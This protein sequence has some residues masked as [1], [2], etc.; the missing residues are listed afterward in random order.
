MVYLVISLILFLIGYPITYRIEKIKLGKFKIPDALAAL[1]TIIL[2]LSF[3]V[4][5]FFLILPPLINEAKTLSGLNFYDVLHN[6]L[7][8]FPTLK[9]LLLKFGTEDELK[10]QLSKQFNDFSNSFSIS[11]IANNI[12]VYFSTIIGGTLCVLFITF[13]F[14]KDENIVRSSILSITPK[15]VENDIRVVLVT[16]KKMLSR[17]FSALFIDMIIVGTSVFIL[18]SVFS[19]KNAL[20]IATVAGILN[21]IPYVGSAI[22]LIIA[23]FLGLSSCI[24]SGN[25]ELMAPTINKIFFSI[26][27]VI[28]LDG[29]IVQPYLFSN[30]VKAHPLEIFIV[31]LMAATIGGI[32]GMIVALPVY[33]LIRIIAKE[34]LTHVKFFR[35]ISESIDDK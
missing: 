5:L 16:S 34:F 7:N 33:T 15:D 22:T 27:G 21:V 2:L 1:I 8:Q 29:F 23:L 28:A 3:F 10:I 12:S 25:Y 13:F 20:I 11:Q 14:L 30:S 31:T 17:Y 24:S 18:M 32:V 35:K 9:N 6:S 19:I 26:L 4:F